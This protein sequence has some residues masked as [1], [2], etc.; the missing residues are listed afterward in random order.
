MFSRSVLRPA[1]QLGNVKILFPELSVAPDIIR[2]KNEA[3]ETMLTECPPLCYRAS[4]T[5]FQQ[6]ADIRRY[7]S[8]CRVRRRILLLLPQSEGE[9]SCRIGEG[10]GCEHCQRRTAEDLQGRRA[11]LRQPGARFGGGPYT[12][13]EEVQISPRRRQCRERAAHCL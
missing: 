4:E 8:C 5:F 9:R 10:Q 11:R 2:S 6:C 3:D 13:H 1:R 12:Q 7:R